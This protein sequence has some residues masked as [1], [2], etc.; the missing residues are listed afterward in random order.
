MR[1]SNRS[2]PPALVISS[3]LASDETSVTELL[4]TVV[5]G[6]PSVEPTAA[7]CPFAGSWAT[8][9]KIAFDVALPPVPRVA[10]AS[11]NGLR[12]YCSRKAPVLA[13]HE[14]PQSS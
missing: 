7:T 3:V 13:A 6:L 2:S 9:V 12:V 14:L 10:D 5:G 4:A 1:A 11:V 8:E